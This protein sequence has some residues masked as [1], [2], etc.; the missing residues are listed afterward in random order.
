ML[1]DSFNRAHD[2][3][4]ISLTDNCNFRCLYCMPD[5]K[6]QLMPRHNLMQSDE[7]FEIAKIFVSVG[8]KKIRLTGGEPLV[9]KDFAE[10]I[11][12]LS[13]LPVKLALTTNGLLLDRYLDNLVFAGIQSVNISI[14]SLQRDRFQKITQRNEL[15]KV[16]KNISLCMDNGIYVKLNVVLMNGFN[17]DEVFD[18]IQFTKNQPVHLRFIEFMP[19]H[20]NQW[21]KD[22][23]VDNQ[24]ILTKIAEEYPLFKLPDQKNATGKKFGI[25]GHSGTVSFISTL[26]D[27]FCATCNRMRLTADGKMKNCLFGVEEFDVLGAFRRGENIVPLI[28]TAVL[29]KHQKLGG[30]FEDYKKL[31]PELLENRSMIKIGG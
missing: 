28:E 3:L 17:E 26:T 15:E 23:V 11:K 16:L 31:R 9:R 13:L 5:E 14:D 21:E 24:A 27:S 19:F 25:L 7:I 8:V 2:Y 1:I 22:K 30:Q 4:R 12:T 20:K 29:K 10:I 18:F 6:I